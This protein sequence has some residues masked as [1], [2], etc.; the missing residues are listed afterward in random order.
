MYEYIFN[1]KIFILPKQIIYLICFICISSFLILSYVLNTSSH[2]TTLVKNSCISEEFKERI[3]S[4]HRGTE[5]IAYLTFDDGPTPKVTPKILD[6]LKEENVKA[7]FFVLGKCVSYYPEIVKRTYEEGHFIANHGYTHN[8]SRLYKTMDNFAQEIKDTDVEIA[9]AIGVDEYCSHVFRFPNGFTSPRYKSEKKEARKL[10][11]KLGYAYIDWN[12]LNGDSEK[13]CS[14]SG[15][16]NNLK[17]S[18]K[19]KGTLVILMHDTADLNDSSA[20]LK[21]SIRFLK[22]EGYTFRTFQDLLNEK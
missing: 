5:K 17:K 14:K 2:A 18:A 9:K 3:S 22:E 4:L 11:D 7:T 6:I 12:C 10:L 13:K 20:V 19:N 16:L 1:M 15:L 21:D 8:N